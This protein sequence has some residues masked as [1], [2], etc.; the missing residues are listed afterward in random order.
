M[1]NAE[2]R[3]RIERWRDTMPTLFYTPA[4]EIAFKGFVTKE[5]LSLEEAAKRKFNDMPVG[6]PWGG[7]WEYCWFKATFA[8]PKELAG[9][10]VAMKVVSGGESVVFID[11]VDLGGNSVAG[12]DGPQDIGGRLLT[13]TRKA[14]GGES[15]EVMVEG[16][17][18][19]GKRE[20]GGGPCPHGHE[21][22]PE[23]APTQVSVGKS[24]FGVWNEEMFQLWLDTETLLQLHDEIGDKESL[25]AA[26]IVQAL[27]DMTLAVDL[28][29]PE[30]QMLRTIREG[31]KI[32]K[33]ALEARNGSTQG[34]MF[35][36]GHSHIDVAWLWPLEETERKCA[37]TFGSQLAL[38]EEYPEFKY[39]QS[40]PHT[41]QMVKDLYPELY[42]RVKKAVKSG[43]WIPEGGMWVEPDTNVTG[44]ESLIRQ[45]IHG[46]RFFKEEFGVDSQMMWLPDVFG[47][48]GSLPQ[49]MAGCGIT[50][51]STQKIFWT[52]NGGDQ[53]PYN[54]FWWEGI[55][56]T[57]VMS[58]IHNDY[59]S[60]THP[61][62]I[63]ARW[64]ERVQKDAFHS[65]RLVPFGHGDGGGG[66]TRE[67][68]EFLRRER[69]LEG[70][71]KCEIRHPVDYFKDI[72]TDRMPTWAGELYFQAHRGT[73]TTQAK[74]KKA[75]RKSE[76]ALREA[77]MWGCAAIAL[78]KFKFPLEKADALWK[79]V[80]L[81]QFHD[82]IPG[83]SIHRVYERN[84][85]DLGKVLT[86][87]AEIDG[88]AKDKL[89]KANDASAITVFNSLSWERNALV[90]LPK[91]VEAL[92][93]VPAQKCDGAAYALTEK[94][95]SCGWKSFKAGKASTLP[96]AKA[97]KVD[98]DTIE[99]EFI[100]VRV[101]AAGEIASMVDKAS[102]REFA[103][104]PCNRL[105]LFKDVPSWF[106]AWDIDSTYK[107]QEIEL[108]GKASVK[109]LAK[110]P[111]FAAVRVTRAFGEST[112]TQD[113]VVKA[114]SRRVD[115]KTSVDWKESHKMLKA[116]FPVEVKA[117]DAIE[118]IQFGHVRRPTHS[119]KPYDFHRFEVCN[120]KWT[121]LVEEGRGAAVLNDCKY[122]VGVEG[123]TIGLTLLRSPLAPDMTAD[124]GLQE[125]TYSFMVWDG[126]F[127]D[128]GLVKEGYELN[129]P[130]SI[131]K[132]SAKDMSL[133]SVD[134]P[135]VVVET[136][137]P[138]ED[139]SG[140]IVVRLYESLRTATG[141]TLSLGFAARKATLVNMLEEA[142]AD[143]K[144][145]DGKLALEFKPF[146]IKTI[147]FKQ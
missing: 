127:K 144:L 100:K 105:R 84:L 75:N 67:H 65:A 108:G 19:H 95:P 22:V 24:T 76:F 83:S 60:L 17:A 46:K 2:W 34:E 99:N 130:A 70:L 131:A 139:G 104:A 91:G 71:P 110:G 21:M 18:G 38:M 114:G 111:L 51:F 68:L 94:L 1:I 15:F 120:H 77:E 31:R 103:A 33:P 3:R 138:A 117:E 88:A 47:Y 44:G 136:V 141:A 92:E 58:Y 93:G 69:D 13:L 74:T 119:N 28:E 37:R 11:G 133:L 89:I 20:C 56:G 107:K 66:P 39:L 57:K 41:Y 42:K 49:I 35:C 53:F 23:P 16:Y 79:L 101:N 27:E 55:D 54:I 121:A 134:A 112:F 48:T 87:A 62:A 36:F 40:Q 125:F 52:Y 146:E 7:K 147:R 45:F 12:W 86:G 118:E 106:D 4:G 6:T 29:L 96:A 50:C 30:E 5:Q 145:K 135:G 122:G 59:N 123:S 14:K 109:F 129:A 26:A 82:I 132:G 32:L 124:K 9:K 142:K 140:D 116:S 25:R 128:S 143:L 113:I 80:L 102:G 97:V 64:R 63:M 73:Y 61:K 126:A 78:S 8:I 43:Q 85:E 81:N 115:F 137:K 98:G 72:D 90:E 10:R